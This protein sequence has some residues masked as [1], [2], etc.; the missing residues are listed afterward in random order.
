MAKK[1]LIIALLA[2][3]LKSAFDILIGN[4]PFWYDPARDL[5]AAQANLQKIS[6]IGPT[7][8]IPG[9]FYGPYWIWWL[10]SGLVITRDPRL[11]AI[12]TTLLPYFIFL[13][14]LLSKMFGKIF[15]LVIALAY[16]LVY[17]SYTSQLWNPHLAPLLFVGLVYCL[18]FSKRLFWLAGFLCGLIFNIHMSFGIAVTAAAS[19]YI[20]ISR[21]GFSFFIGLAFSFIPFMVFEARHGFNQTRVFFDTFIG[22]LILRRSPVAVTGLSKGKILWQFLNIPHRFLT[23]PLIVILTGDL[24]LLWRQ[25][26]LRFGLM[27]KRLLRFLFLALAFI[28]LIYFGSKN[29][30]WSY[31]FIAVDM[32]IL[33]ILGLF[34]GSTRISKTIFILLLTVSFA[35]NIFNFLR[36]PVPDVFA[37]S[38]IKSKENIVNLVYKDAEGKPF[39]VFA[40]SSAIYTFDYDYLFGWLGH[41]RPTP[42]SELVYLII[43]EATTAVKEDFIHYRTPV[44]SY[45]TVNEWTMPDGTWVIKRVKQ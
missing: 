29:P 33:L 21:R 1:A 35:S 24:L 31:H 25:G 9:I 19:V 13:P 20:L 11:I 3:F 43:P 16:L 5:L 44:K 34:I 28:V 39:S 2:L 40:Y 4:L 30:V 27:E 32:L 38:A 15:G 7:T 42:D 12:L 36:K 17:G 37:G 10:S 41:Y 45:V 23:L 18:V 14:W 8:G 22:S 26:T 6:L